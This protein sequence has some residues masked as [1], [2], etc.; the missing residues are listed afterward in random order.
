V[1]AKY[2]QANLLSDDLGPGRYVLLEVSD[3]GSGMSP[4]TL[5]RIFDPFFTTKFTG[6]GLG[7]AA[8][9]GI[10]RGHKGAI[11]IN[12]KLG[13][14]TTF[15]V[16]LPACESLV[17]TTSKPESIPNDFSGDATILVVDDEEPVQKMVRSTLEKYGYHVLTAANGREA[18][19]VFQNNH[20]AIDLVLLDMTMPVMSGE[21][22]LLRLREVRRDIR[23]IVSSGYNEIEALRRFGETV[24]GFLQKPYRANQL[25]EKIKLT[26][27]S[28][29]PA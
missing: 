11:K 5:S 28:R 8:V 14:G 4:E 25:G 26:L 3:T 13:E 19:K 16:L 1:D 22:T 21:E 23:V 20:K 12:S 10:V 18:L 17:S 15:K 2:I 27:Q 29:T 24:N 9:L 6:R 7:L